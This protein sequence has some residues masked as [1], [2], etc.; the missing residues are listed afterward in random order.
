MDGNNV[1]R[2]DLQKEQNELKQTNDSVNEQLDFTELENV[3]GGANNDPK[4]DET[5]KGKDKDK[6]NKG[7]GGGLL[8]WC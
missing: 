6:E 4:D 1:K 7:S 3:Q 5:A 2:D 8:C